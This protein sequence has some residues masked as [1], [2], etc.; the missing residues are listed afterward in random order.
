MRD[1][2]TL[3][4]IFSTF[5]FLTQGCNKKDE[6][7][8]SNKVETTQT[9]KKIDNSKKLSPEYLEVL[10]KACEQFPKDSASM[11]RFYSRIYDKNKV[12]KQIQRIEDLLTPEVIDR[13][14]KVDQSL[15]KLLQNAVNTNSLPCKQT[16][17]IALLYSYFDDFGGDAMCDQV[18]TED[19]NYDLVWKSFQIMIE[20]SRNDTCY[21][22][23]L[24]YLDNHI[25]TNVELA[26]AM[27]DF[28]V[29]AIQNNTKG[30]LDM[31][32]SRNVEDQYD[33]SKYI[34]VYD[35]PDSTLI[36]TLNDISVNSVSDNY[37]IAATEILKNINKMYN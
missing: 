10:L 25:R 4:F 22:S 30:F 7:R 37:K 23:S 19:D 15:K 21:I 24:I 14:N 33:F 20:E 13:Y 34:S 6:S 26:E 32:N 29:R 31:Y 28:I 1:M 5:L 35:Q 12:Q 16:D 27:P 11:Y 8:N 17:S 2:R 9:E 36:N 3:I 18:L